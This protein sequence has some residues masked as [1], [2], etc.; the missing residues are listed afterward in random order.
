MISVVNRSTEWASFSPSVFW[1]LVDLLNQI[2][3]LS[4]AAA[5]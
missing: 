2:S 4:E 5:I 3:Y 1:V